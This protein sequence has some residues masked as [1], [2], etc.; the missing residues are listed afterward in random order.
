MWECMTM[1]EYA[2]FEAGN[3]SEVFKIDGVWWKSVRPFFYQPLFPLHEF[4]PFAKRPPLA[5]LLGGFQHLVPDPGNANS[6][7][8]FFV[9]ENV[10]QYSIG[11]INHQF[12]NNI[13]RGMKFYSIREVAT[14]EEFVAAGHPVYLSFYERT[15]YGYKKE[16]VDKGNFAGWAA[17]LYRFPKIKKLGAY[18][19]GELAALDISYQLEDVVMEATSFSRTEDLKYHVLDVMAHALREGA[20]A[21]PG[22]RLIMRGSVTGEKRIDESKVR[23]G[24]TILSKPA[25]YQMNLFADL[26]LRSF[27]KN[28]YV[29]L[30][31]AMDKVPIRTLPSGSL[32]KALPYSSP[33]QEG[34][35]A[36]PG[37]QTSPDRATS[38]K[39]NRA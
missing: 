38:S 33:D 1:D 39:E 15:R 3:G 28:Q 22:I 29:K 21:S 5:A 12:R 31:G 7:K 9:W 27:M 36:R 37:T 13:Q 34:A 25:Y 32:S 20:A 35:S 19:G 26:L 2:E 16:R 18:R 14:R 10:R 11:R 30:L 8:N 6:Q 4:A 24:C 17:N 23:R